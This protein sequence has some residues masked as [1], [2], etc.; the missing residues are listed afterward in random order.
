MTHR[1]AQ[2]DTGS[3]ETAAYGL[4]SFSSQNCVFVRRKEKIPT[5]SPLHLPRPPRLEPV[6]VTYS[7][8][9]TSFGCFS[10]QALPKSLLPRVPLSANMNGNKG[11][12]PY[13]SKYTPEE[14]L[15]R[16]PWCTFVHK[17]ES[18]AD[19]RPRTRH[20]LQRQESCSAPENS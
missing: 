5:M 1:T 10:L 19:Q 8:L 14:A 20:F 11:T 16:D 7:A 3:L 6:G 4:I 18:Q 12:S 15:S 2:L 13:H 9:K 17:E